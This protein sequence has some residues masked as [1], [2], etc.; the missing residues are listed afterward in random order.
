[1]ANP[2]QFKHLDPSN[3]FGSLG[4]IPD[5]VEAAWQAIADRTFPAS[6]RD[7]KHLIVAGMGGSAIGTHLI[8]SVFRDRLSLPVT[9]VSDYRLPAWVDRETLIL[10]SS[11]SGGTEEVMSVAKYGQAHDLPMMAL[12]TGGDLAAFAERHKVPAV[13]FKSEHNPCGQPRIGLGYAVTYQLGIFRQLGFIDLTNEEMGA[14]L[15]LLRSVNAIYADLSVPNPSLDLAYRARLRAPLIIASE[16]LTGNAHILANQWNENAKN[17]AAWF[18]IPE[19]NHHLLEGLT[20]PPAVR[21]RLLAVLLHS[22]LYDERNQKRYDITR[23]VLD[24]QKIASISINPH[25]KTPLEQAFDMLLLGAYASFY[26][27]VLNKINPS[28]IPWVDYFKRL[29]SA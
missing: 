13:L 29:M 28:P 18:A 19:L 9:I 6:L 5:Q 3:M 4:A 17:M 1:M 11:Y 26:Q 7:C 10:L 15:S 2:A 14:A 22:N 16:H 20:G 27:A 8:Q 23:Q 21:N 25:G 24:E 12:T